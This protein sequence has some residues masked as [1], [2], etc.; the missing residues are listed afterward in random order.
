MT[1]G[2][3]KYCPLATQWCNLEPHSDVISRSFCE[4]NPFVHATMVK[5]LSFVL[6]ANSVFM[7]LWCLQRRITSLPLVSHCF[8]P[9]PS[10]AGIWWKSMTLNFSIPLIGKVILLVHTYPCHMLPPAIP[11]NGLLDVQGGNWIMA[12]AHV[13]TSRWDWGTARQ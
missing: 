7:R 12:A 5:R 8:P 3:R 4:V 11:T 1:V 6:Q 9:P 2:N 13:T 10:V